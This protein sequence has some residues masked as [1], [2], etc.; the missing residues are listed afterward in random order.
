RQ[1]A[2]LG[3][4]GGRAAGLSGHPAGG[5]PVAVYG[6][7]LSGIPH[8]DTARNSRTLWQSAVETADGR[9]VRH[10]SGR[11]QLSLE[12][13]VEFRSKLEVDSEVVLATGC[14]D[15]LR[16][17]HYVKSRLRIT[18]SMA[19]RCLLEECVHFLYRIIPK[20]ERLRQVAKARAEL[21]VVEVSPKKRKKPAT[22]RPAAKR[23]KPNA[24]AD[25]P[26]KNSHKVETPSLSTE[27][28]SGGSSASQSQ[29]STSGIPTPWPAATPP[30]NPTPPPPVAP[31]LPLPASCPLPSISTSAGLLHRLRQPAQFGFQRG[32]PL[33]RAAAAAGRRRAVHLEPVG[34][35]DRADR[36]AHAGGHREW[37]RRCL[38]GTGAAYVGDCAYRGACPCANRPRGMVAREDDADAARQLKLCAQSE[39]KLWNSGIFT[40]DGNDLLY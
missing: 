25:T 40:F 3:R 39:G 9:A 23:V 13:F 12:E 17:K 18:Q 21:P 14:D 31:L 16:V 30:P 34:H 27:S 32:E 15:Y 2:D 24:H 8:Q 22:A 29:D 26:T 28:P 20:A 11:A 36:F 35:G 5:L 37:R 7:H 19:D 33:V 4:D 10:R 1:S 38:D 6:H